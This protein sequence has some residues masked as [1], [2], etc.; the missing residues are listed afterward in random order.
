MP[1][2]VT[3]TE[4]GFIMDFWWKASDDGE[5]NSISLDIIGREWWRDC[6]GRIV[7]GSDEDCC[8]GV[9]GECTRC[10]YSFCEYF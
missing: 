8:T 7:N 1:V 4:S 6:S 10:L 9:F 5:S 2:T 3:G